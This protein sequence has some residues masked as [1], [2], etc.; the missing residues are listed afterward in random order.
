MLK[1]IRQYFKMRVLKGSKSAIKNFDSKNHTFEIYNGWY[2]TKIAFRLGKFD[3][4]V[5]VLMSGSQF[6]SDSDAMS[7]IM[8][9]LWNFEIPQNFSLDLI[10]ELKEQVKER[11]KE[12]FTDQAAEVTE[13]RESDN[14]CGQGDQ[15]TEQ[16]EGREAE[17]QPA[18][19]RIYFRDMYRNVMGA[20]NEV[21]ITLR[22]WK[23]IDT[24]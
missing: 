24:L 5:Y 12:N 4:E 16:T 8:Q 1:E 9:L 13:G 17:N 2:S 7:R 20:P 21:L 22:L 19:E 3:N 10:E 14:R 6:V 23:P 11:R 15:N 18:E